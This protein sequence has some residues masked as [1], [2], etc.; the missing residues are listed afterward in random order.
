MAWNRPKENGEAVSRPLLKR[1][2]DRFPLKGAIAGAIVVIGAAVAAWWL[3]PEGETRQDAAS[4]KRGLIKEVTPAAAAKVAV[5]PEAEQAKKE[6]PQRV[7][8]V[9]NGYRLLCDGRLQKVSPHPIEVG[10]SNERRG[11]SF[12]DRCN[13]Q[14]ADLVQ[15]EPGEGFVGDSEVDFAGFDKDFAKS[16]LAPVRIEPDDSDYDK[17]VKQAVIDL[18][19]ELVARLKDG[20]DIV[21]L[22]VDTREQLRE[23]ATYREDLQGQVWKLSR[24]RKLTEQDRADLIEAANKMLEERGCKKLELP[25]AF[26]GIIRVNEERMKGETK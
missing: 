12:D 1:S 7:G 21:R 22:L 26:D 16:V 15:I 5:A 9:R 25:E 3:W 17:Q 13:Q 24:N 8:E 14:L 4:T 6:K 20:E 2:G 23:L 11:P 19:K 18:K 10:A